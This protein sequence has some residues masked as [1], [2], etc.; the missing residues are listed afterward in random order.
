MSET[1][2]FGTRLTRRKPVEM[3]VSDT[4]GADAEH[5]HLKRGITLFQLIMFGVGSTIG[6][7]IFFVLAETVPKAGPA[8]IISFIM[9]G[10]V[11]GLT[12]L[13]YA[14][15]ASMIP[16]SG[17]SYS[18]AYA[19]LGEIVAYFVGACLLLEYGISA[20]A[21]AIGWSGY[22]NKVFEI[23][24]GSGLPAALSAAPIVA[25]GY[26][27]SIGGDGYLNLPAAIL[28]FLCCL[29]LIRGSKESARANA[30][31]VVIKICVLILFIAIAA[32]GF[33]S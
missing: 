23:V 29:L 16:V 14:E 1:S 15:M 32:T 19:T 6:T 28:V 10:V 27:L 13:C 20:S 8:V 22:L 21:V 26:A 4:A 3:L 7:G 12:A 18:Y 31:M 17:S 24:F 2:G 25:D 5:G 30:I 33:N 9:A 11:A